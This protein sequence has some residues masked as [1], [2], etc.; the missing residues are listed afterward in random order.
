MDQSKID[1][2]LE[3]FSARGCDEVYKII[4]HLENGEILEELRALTQHEQ[5]AILTE[6]K[7]IMSV[8][9]ARS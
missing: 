9:S 2:C 6:L 3:Q 7:S 8:Y 5:V 1:D 4:Q